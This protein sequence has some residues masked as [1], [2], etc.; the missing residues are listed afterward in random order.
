MRLLEPAVQA[1]V[2]NAFC[3]RQEL[4]QGRGMINPPDCFLLASFYINGYGTEIDYAEAKRLLNFAAI[5]HHEQSEAYVYRFWNALTL[6]FKVTG[7][8][9]NLLEVSALK[10]SRTALEDLKT[11]A[12]DRVASTMVSIRTS[13]A[14]QGANFYFKDQML[15]GLAH[16]P[17]QDMLV[18]RSSIAEKL[19][20]VKDKS[21]FRVNKRGD[22]I[23]HI[24]AS[25][26]WSEAVEALIDT[27]SV[28]VN[29]LNDQGE[30]ALLSACRA[31]QPNVVHILLRLGADASISTTQN[32]SPLHWLVSFEAEDV[33]TIGEGLLKA[34]ASSKLQTTAPISYSVFRASIETDH[35]RPGSPLSWAVHHDRA[36]IVRFMLDGGRDVSI[37]MLSPS[38]NDSSPLLWAAHYHH[39]ECLQLMCDALTRANITF[40][41]G[42]LVY[43]AITSANTFSMILR[44]G[45]RY[46]EKLY[47]TFDYLLTETS[48]TIFG[49]GIGL[50]GYTAL[51]TA[52]TSLSDKV[53]EY[54]L[55]DHVKD[56]LFKD[57]NLAGRTSSF[58]VFHPAHMNQP[59]G[60]EN[61][62]PILESIRLNRL[63]V[64][65]LLLAHGGDPLFQSHNP[66]NPAE[67]NWTGLHI[68][69][70]AAHNQSTPP[71]L[72]AILLDTGIPVDGRPATATSPETP[73]SI[74]LSNA[75]LHLARH[76]LSHDAQINALST[77]NC[78]LIS[79]YPLTILG[80]T[81]AY[82]SRST[83]TRLRFLLHDCSAT[84]SDQHLE[85]V[86]EP[87]R[88]LTALQRAA[89]AYHGMSFVSPEGGPS[90][91]LRWEDIDWETN[92]SVI[93]ALLERFGN[94][95]LITARCM[96][97]GGRTALH[98]AI[99]AGN[100]EGVKV[101]VT[102]DENKKRG[103]EGSKNDHY[104]EGE[105]GGAEEEAS[106]RSEK[107]GLKNTRNDQHET[108][109]EY[110][111]RLF[112]DA[113]REEVE[114]GN[115]NPGHDKL[116]HTISMTTS[117]VAT[118][119]REALGIIIAVLKELVLKK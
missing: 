37:G 92:R 76:F 79:E 91:A 106:P 38:D 56:L 101:L 107:L 111:I 66:Y 58:G 63:P 40:T 3:S 59:C 4:D 9:K 104:N 33:I 44:H 74:A 8:L 62:T 108:P 96:A 43:R 89:W 14:G 46:L 23:L 61:R 73:F 77:N 35:Q 22:R 70:H 53:V 88:G 10:G 64:F 87:E 52:V 5:N 105:V 68:I 112:A 18:S 94:E 13:T 30:T 113:Q 69:A 102:W 86:V 6:E 41:Y 29:L 47:E 32:E 95:E 114:Q 21:N 81:V 82:T 75:A 99:E 109:A 93:V 116:S 16:W 65:N 27:Y 103:N 34:G 49:A 2:F 42:G 60:V 97:L 24:A 7:G 48:N 67:S 119:K 54:L 98:F 84:V 25:C 28:P 45:D 19:K 15:H 31:G 100:V 90:T 26:G 78:L 57:D 11:A 55:S 115:K 50:F 36:D 72:L 17:W 71:P 85:S 51:Y 80:H 83:L 12:P 39:A 1:F 117:S 20:G 118:S 110:A